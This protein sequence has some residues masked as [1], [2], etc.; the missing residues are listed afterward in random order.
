MPVRLVYVVIE[1]ASLPVGSR[2]GA[3]R[4]ALY[5]YPLRLLLERVSWL[6][7]DLG[8]EAAITLAA[9]RGL[10]GRVP[11]RYV[12]RLRTLGGQTEIRWQALRPKIAIHQAV[13]RDGLQI[14]DIAAGAL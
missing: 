4:D 6:V 14:A 11:R 3:N 1:K 13:T 8:G 12:D 10:P 2:M 7:D 9:V 5:N